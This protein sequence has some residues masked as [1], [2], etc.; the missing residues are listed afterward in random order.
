[1]SPQVMSKTAK[2]SREEKSSYNVAIRIPAALME[3]AEA[4][5][6]KEAKGPRKF[7]RYTLSDHWRELIKR[8]ISTVQSNQ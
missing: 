6:K 8:G 7:S 5:Y 4:S 1:M 2:K 3:L